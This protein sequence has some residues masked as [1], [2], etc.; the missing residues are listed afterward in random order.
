VLTPL[1]AAR[2]LSARA[3]A[4][5]TADVVSA[6]PP[7]VER[8]LGPILRD[9]AEYV[10]PAYS[11]T[12]AEG[13]LTSNLL[14]PLTGAL[15]GVRTQ[16]VVGGCAAFSAGLADRLLAG[17]GWARA[18]ASQG[19]EVRLG[20]EALLSGRPVVET[21][22]GI[23]QID[24][25]PAPPDLITTLVGIVGPLFQFMDDH[26]VV[27]QSVRGSHAVARVGE[28]P[29]FLAAAGEVHVDRMVR[30]FRLGLKD[31][32][33]VWEQIMPEETLGRLYPLG[34]LAPDEFRLPPAVWARVIADFAVAHHERR[35]ARDHLLRAL[36]PLYLGRV[37]AFLLETQAGPPARIEHV[38]ETV[39]LA[40]GAERAF[41]VDRWR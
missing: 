35:L 23:K 24:P 21:H 7:W 37:A 2:H 34:L 29:A 16:Q 38:L 39:G 4:F 25:G 32:L 33:P 30:A 20:I 27:W 13:T 28:P 11:R 15:S 10:S 14:A 8:L 36:T 19:V 12:A 5:V 3:C 41:L 31:L 17:P 9:E 6:A 40:F 22:L 18:A 26:A 1:A